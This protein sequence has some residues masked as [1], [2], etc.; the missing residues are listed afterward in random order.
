MHVT[1]NL[2]SSKSNIEFKNKSEHIRL[3]LTRI[4]LWIQTKI[5]KTQT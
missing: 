3:S 1:L 2:M 4:Q 5:E